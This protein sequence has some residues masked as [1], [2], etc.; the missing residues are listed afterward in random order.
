MA[1]DGSGG[2]SRPVS[3][4]TS[5]TVIDQ[6][7]VNS[8]MDGIATGL[9]TCITKDGQTTVSANI[10]MNSKKFTGLTTGSSAS[11]SLNLGQAQAEAYIWCGTAGGTADAITL[12][13]TPAISAYAAGQRFVWI[14]SASPNTGAA[15]VNISGL[16]TK[17]LQNDGAA[18]SAGDHAANK[19]YIGIYDGTQFQISRFRVLSAAS[20]TASG[21]VELATTAETTTGTDTTR[22]V[23]PDG[24]HDMTSLSGAAW[25][26]D[27]DDMS[28]DSATKVASQQS[29]KAYVDTYAVPTLS[30]AQ[31]STS[32]TEI[33]F[34]SIPSWVKEINILLSG[35]SLSG[36]D[37]LLVQI[38]DSGGFETSSYVSQSFESNGGAAVATGT[39]TSGFIVNAVGASGAATGVITLRLM[40]SSTNLWIEDHSVTYGTA[41]TS[42]R[43]A[44][45]KA[46]SA[47]LD[48]VRITRTGTDTFDAGSINIQYK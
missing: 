5:G 9:S 19:M 8:E 20:D 31:A 7:S 46:L 12:T 4:Y 3:S 21:I 13:P 48:R 42:S 2:F 14:A 10:P 23:T 33:D 22:A 45:S 37:D 29:I 28:S 6:D 38:G 11:D 40:N 32:G 25:M 44:G 43:G 15:T 35:V 17:A 41:G 18:L 16:G 34:T 30:T 1:F 27:E 24:L 39:S 36:T 47:A 26:L